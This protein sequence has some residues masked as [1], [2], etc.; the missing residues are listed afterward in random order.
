MVLVT[1]REATI[2]GTVCLRVSQIP[3]INYEES[4]YNS[5]N[6]G[7]NVTK[8]HAHSWRVQYK[9]EAGVLEH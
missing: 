2:G 6:K 8:Q 1:T 3:R 7:Y 9:P 4:V 5:E